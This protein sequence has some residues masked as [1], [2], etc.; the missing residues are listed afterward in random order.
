M[1][2]EG[3]A[4]AKASRHLSWHHPPGNVSSGPAVPLPHLLQ[5]RAVE[6]TH[7][8]FGLEETLLLPPRI[9]GSFHV[10]RAVGVRHGA[11][12]IWGREV[13]GQCLRLG[14]AGPLVLTSQDPHWGGGGRRANPHKPS[15]G[16]NDRAGR[17]NTK[18]Q[19]LKRVEL[20]FFSPDGVGRS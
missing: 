8:V 4:H 2:E 5:A 17:G 1:G 18:Q 20:P 14:A 15:G 16:S 9:P 6:P 12:D 13:E 11:T 7:P 10:L 19:Q 3:W